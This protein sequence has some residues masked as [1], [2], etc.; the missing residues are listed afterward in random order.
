VEIV[1]DEIGD[2]EDFDYFLYYVG[3]HFGCDEHIARVGV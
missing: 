1:A 2:D 3:C